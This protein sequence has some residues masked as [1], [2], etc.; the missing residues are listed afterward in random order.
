[1]PHGGGV[2]IASERENGLIVGIVK[3]LD[4]PEDLG[5][6]KVTY[7]TLGD[8]ESDWCRLVAPFA[9]GGRGAFFRPEVDD[10]V[11]VAFEHGDPRRPYV[12]GGVWS[13]ADKPPADDGKKKDNNWRFLVS[14]SGHV[15]K[16]DDTAG[17]EVVEVSDGGGTTRVVLE[18]A[19]GKVRVESDGGDVEVTAMAGTVKVEA[20]MVEI[21]A[22][23]SAT[24]E[25]GGAL[26]LKGSVVN[27]N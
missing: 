17:A 3:S 9:G 24:L 27:I 20:A 1:V 25:A 18:T 14:R 13:K 8:E 19:S 2:A 22:T 23:G 4:D 26:T 21:K 6:V 5:R 11:L 16:L 12:L 7:P 15:V 10:E